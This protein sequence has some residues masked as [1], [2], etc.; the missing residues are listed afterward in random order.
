[1]GDLDKY[2]G[3]LLKIKAMYY[4]EEVAIVGEQIEYVRSE[5]SQFVGKCFRSKLVGDKSV[6]Y[7][8]I[9]LPT[10]SQDSSGHIKFEPYLLH[11]IV[12]MRWGEEAPTKYRL[13]KVS[14]MN[15]CCCSKGADHISDEYEEIS[16]SEFDR[17]LLEQIHGI[18]SYKGDKVG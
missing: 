2:R 10:A 16:Q 5:F 7:K 9:G 12:V 6:C 15:I 1:M 8:V 13:P 14:Y 18:K 4:N 3:D 11:A 17:M